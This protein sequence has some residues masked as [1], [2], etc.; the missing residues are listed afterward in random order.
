MR[1]FH[2]KITKTSKQTMTDCPNI[3]CNPHIHWWKQS[4][5]VRKKIFVFIWS[6]TIEHY[7]ESKA[8][9]E[10][11]ANKICLFSKHEKLQPVCLGWAQGQMG[12]P[13]LWKAIKFCLISFQLWK[14]WQLV[15]QGNIIGKCTMYEGGRKTSLLKCDFFSSEQLSSPPTDYI[16]MIFFVFLF[17]FLAVTK[18]GWVGEGV[19]R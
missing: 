15:D 6:W 16:Q 12:T 9:V 5:G 3:N 2:L 18:C 10:K 13:V 4:Q 1:Q 7:W 19:C 17:N 14:S 8:P 11:W